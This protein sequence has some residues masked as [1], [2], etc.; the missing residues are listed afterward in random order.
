MPTDWDYVNICHPGA[1]AED[2]VTYEYNASKARAAGGGGAPA[3][4]IDHAERGTYVLRYL[5]AE[6]SILGESAPFDYP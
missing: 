3:L 6:G 2:Y 1:A 5:D 4:M